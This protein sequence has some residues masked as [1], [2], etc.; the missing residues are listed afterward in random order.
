MKSLSDW[1]SN[2]Y[3]SLDQG[4]QEHKPHCLHIGL[5][6]SYQLL[7]SLLTGQKEKLALIIVDVDLQEHRQIMQLMARFVS[8]WEFE[9]ILRT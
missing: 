1:P 7:I 9:V 5:S 2:A 3:H 8:E 6:L 4:F